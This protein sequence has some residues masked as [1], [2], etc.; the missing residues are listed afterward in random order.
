LVGIKCLIAQNHRLWMICLSYVSIN[1]C[2]SV[3][4]IVKDPHL[5]IPLTTYCKYR[6]LNIS[7]KNQSFDPFFRLIATLTSPNAEYVLYCCEKRVEIINNC[8]LVGFGINAAYAVVVYAVTSAT[9]LGFP[10]FFDQQSLNAM[11]IETYIGCV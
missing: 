6:I 9:D 7:F 4:S 2:H 3:K 10:S 11:I 1:Q 8:V 5:N